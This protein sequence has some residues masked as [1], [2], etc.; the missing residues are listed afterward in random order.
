MPENPPQTVNREF[1]LRKAEECIRNAEEAAIPTARAYW[2]ALAERWR[3]LA[4]G[5]QS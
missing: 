3:A 1:F 5:D 2:L 4:E